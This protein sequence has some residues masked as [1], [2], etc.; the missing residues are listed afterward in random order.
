MKLLGIK[1]HNFSFDFFEKNTVP[2]FYK[3]IEAVPNAY[4]ENSILKDNNV[5]IVNCIMPY[6]GKRESTLNSDYGHYSKS[7]RLGYAMDFSNSSSAIDYLKNVLGKKTYKSIR[8]D[9]QRLYRDHNIQLKVY[10]GEMD[11]D[12]YT[13]LLK[14]LKGYIFKR[15][16]GRTHT[17]TALSKWDFYVPTC[18]DMILSK[19]AAMFVLYDNDLPIGISLSFRHKSILTAAITSFNENYYKYSLGKLMFV[20]QI[21]WCFLNNCTLLDTG[22]GN[23]PYKIKFSNAVFYYD[24]KVF[25]P[26]K[27]LAKKM[28]AFF[29]SWALMIKYYCIVVFKEKRYNSPKKTFKNRWLNLSCTNI[30]SQHVSLKTESS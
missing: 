20:N 18:Y 16:E 2:P 21:E 14:T 13:Y 5:H 29:I 17:H 24:T 10:H 1:S 8:Q 15:F 12:H 23:I 4:F 27:N 25:Y 6:I 7:Y 26:K 22:W 11:K 19:N 9:R 28:L 3:E 30:H